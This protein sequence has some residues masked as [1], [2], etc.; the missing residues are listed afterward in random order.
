MQREAK[1]CPFYGMPCEYVPMAEK[2]DAQAAEI[3][4]LRAA[5]REISDETGGY[6]PDMTEDEARRY[7]SSPLFLIQQKARAALGEKE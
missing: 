1:T 5:L 4:R 6:R 3:E 7:F 2:A